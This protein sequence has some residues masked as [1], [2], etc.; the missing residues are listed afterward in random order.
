MTATLP[1]DLVMYCP[2]CHGRHLDVGKWYTRPHHTHACQHCGACWRPAVQ[3][4]RGV[5]FLA[6]FK[7]SDKV[8]DKK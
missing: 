2:Q 7:D 6:G 5:Q 3:D 8:G 1:V 4:T